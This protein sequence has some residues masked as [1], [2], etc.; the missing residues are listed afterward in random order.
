MAQKLCLWH[1]DYFVW[2]QRNEILDTQILAIA[3][4]HFHVIFVNFEERSQF[5]GF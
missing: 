2:H 4:H 1:Y 5:L 3:L